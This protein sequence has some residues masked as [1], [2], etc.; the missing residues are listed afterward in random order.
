M[1]NRKKVKHMTLTEYASLKRGDL[2]NLRLG[3]NSSTTAKVINLGGGEVLVTY[4]KKTS[5]RKMVSVTATLSPSDL[6]KMNLIKQK[7]DRIRIRPKLT[8]EQRLLRYKSSFKFKK[9]TEGSSV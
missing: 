7:Q 8:R 4:G 6:P 5:D 2:I 1:G 9:G 3:A